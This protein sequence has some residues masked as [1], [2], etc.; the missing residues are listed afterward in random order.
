MSSSCQ[1]ISL[2]VSDRVTE[3]LVKARVSLLDGALVAWAIFGPL[4]D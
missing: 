2:R 3:R 1:L 4:T